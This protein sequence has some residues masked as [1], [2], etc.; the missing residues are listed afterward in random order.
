MMHIQMSWH[1][2]GAGQS[3]GLRGKAKYRCDP[4]SLGAT[5]LGSESIYVTIKGN[6]ACISKPHA[7][8][9][10]TNNQMEI[11]M[12][13]FSQI[14]DCDPERQIPRTTAAG[15]ACDAT[16]PNDQVRMCGVR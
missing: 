12:P 4:K 3:R 1:A 15:W 6:M 5:S 13:S 14:S 8:H 9:V 2:E 16:K 10:H 7:S 11:E